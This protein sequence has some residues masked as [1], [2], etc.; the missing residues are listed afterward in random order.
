[1]QAI[2][3]LCL[4][5]AKPAQAPPLMTLS[6]EPP[7]L[8]PC[9]CGDACPLGGGCERC[10]CTD[11]RPARPEGDGWQWDAH[12]RYWWRPATAAPQHALHPFTPRV[13]TPNPPAPAFSAAPSYRFAPAACA[14]GT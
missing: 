11:P 1:M 14:G 13:M 5:S 9:R 7:L 3:I 4:L 12:G 2:L 10:A 6:Q 8:T